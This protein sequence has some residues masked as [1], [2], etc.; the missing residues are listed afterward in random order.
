MKFRFPLTF[1]VA[2]ALEFGLLVP[3]SAQTATPITTTF[4]SDAKR[5]L[6]S[7]L[8]A[9]QRGPEMERM[10]LQ[11]TTGA[12]QPLIAK[13]GPKLETMPV[14]KQEKARDQLN[15]E[16]KV[17][18]DGIRKMLED[19]MNKSAETSLLPAYMDRFS[20]DEMRQLVT[21]FE[22][23]AFKKYQSVSPELADIW[24]KDVMDSARGAVV[25]KEAVFDTIAT[26]II[27]TESADKKPVAK[28]K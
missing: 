16:L 9:L 4:A 23:P 5:D 6:A 8:V 27:G 2:M 15:A 3:A 11:L 26:K 10:T 21:L 14:A 1:A 18:G 17:L 25:E 24:I 7:K 22:A 13:W 12:I 20:E 19:Q 28:K